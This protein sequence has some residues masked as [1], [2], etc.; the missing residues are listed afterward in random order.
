MLCKSGDK[1]KSPE[2]MIVP[3]RYWNFSWTPQIWSWWTAMLESAMLIWLLES[4]LFDRNMAISRNVMY[5][6]R[7]CGSALQGVVHKMRCT[8]STSFARESSDVAFSNHCNAA[9]HSCCACMILES[10]LQNMISSNKKNDIEFLQVQS[11]MDSLPLSIPFLEMLWGPLTKAA[12][13][14][15]GWE[16]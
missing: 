3:R 6:W 12:A 16:R 15:T 1:A 4:Q 5:E 2:R 10:E 9:S 11:M 14:G 8:S 7:I 13:G